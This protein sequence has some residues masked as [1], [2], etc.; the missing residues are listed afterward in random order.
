MAMYF[1]GSN[2]LDIQSKWSLTLMKTP[3]AVPHCE[4]PKLTIPIWYH[5]KSEFF[6]VTNGP[7]ESPSHESFPKKL[8]QK[9]RVIG[10]L[11][12]KLPIP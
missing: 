2:C 4:A 6:L 12:E 1:Y 11:I 3:G 5:G 9:L 7:P 8:M 10:I